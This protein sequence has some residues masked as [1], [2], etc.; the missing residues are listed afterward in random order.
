MFT[1]IIISLKTRV[2]RV[3]SCKIN[4]YMYMYTEMIILLKTGVTRV[5][6]CNKYIHVQE[7][8][9]NYITPNRS[10]QSRNL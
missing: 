8:R 3:E 7:H 9:N 6:S 10:H 5:E 2:T 4:I 1:K